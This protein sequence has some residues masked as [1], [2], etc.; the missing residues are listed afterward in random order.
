MVATHDCWVRADALLWWLKGGNT[1]PLLTTSPN[2]TPQAQAGVLGQAGTDVIFGSHQLN[3]DMRAGGRIAFGTWFDE[4]DT[5]GIDISYLGL[6]QSTDRYA[7]SG[8]GNPI[9]ARPFFNVDGNPGQ[10]DAHLIAYPGLT[11]GDFHCSSTST[12]QV[13]EFLARWAI[14]RA[15]GYRIELLGGYRFQQLA[16]NL[17]IS[18]AT[19]TASPGTTIPAVDQ[20]YT[21]N[22]F[23]GAEVGVAIARHECRWSVET[24]LKLAL[25]DTHSR[26]DISGAT[27]IGS[28]P[29]SGGFLALPSNI[30]VH[31]MDQFS[32]VP[33]L[34]AT[35]GYDLTRR[36][37]ATAG[38]TFTYWSN[39]SRPG[40]QI[41]LDI[42]PAQI[43]LPSGTSNRPQY[44]QRTSDLWAQGVNIGLDYRF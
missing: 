25:G 22:D 21:K 37:R 29:Y 3:K 2:G 15:P 12:F 24:N 6:G 10:E 26:T 18:E 7:I 33:E 20:F 17:D 40:D 19:G 9:L 32:V 4:C 11:Q 8:D 1:P 38:Y 14:V 30:G 5:I 31:T 36:L 23:H 16:D 44:V 41:D 27:T 39:V 13:A 42:S 28:T 35:V 43:P 34:G